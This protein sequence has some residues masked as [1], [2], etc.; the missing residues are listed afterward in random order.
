MIRH[1]GRNDIRAA[2]VSVAARGIDP[3]YIRVKGELLRARGVGAARRDVLPVLAAW[4]AEQ[5]AARS[6]PI[7]A[8]AAAIAGLTTDLERDAV[9]RRVRELSGG[10]VKIRFCVSNR[11]TGGGRRK[12]KRLTAARHS[13]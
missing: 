7:E 9:R 10:S 11:D 3:S 4:R 12:A 8:A 5:L 6:G 2:I 1:P 13:P